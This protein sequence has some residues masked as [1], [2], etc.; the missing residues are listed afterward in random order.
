MTRVLRIPVLKTV[1]V[2]NDDGTPAVAIFYKEKAY[3]LVSLEQADFFDQF[4]LEEVEGPVPPFVTTPQRET[5]AQIRARL[6]GEEPELVPADEP[7]F[8]EDDVVKDDPLEDILRDMGIDKNKVNPNDAIMRVNDD[9]LRDG[10]DLTE[11]QLRALVGLVEDV[12]RHK[13]ERRQAFERLC[14]IPVLV[15][16]RSA[17]FTSPETRRQIATARASALGLGEQF[18]TI[19]HD[20]LPYVHGD[21]SKVV[22]PDGKG[23][24]VDIGTMLGEFEDSPIARDNPAVI[25]RDAGG[26]RWDATPT[27]ELERKASLSLRPKG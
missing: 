12:T 22:A 25:A 24:T 21:V 7:H 1:A 19:P 4:L 11:A 8:H 3:F 13:T 16:Q 20:L 17:K 27:K 6:L 14:T 2:P 23:G 18:M 15:L 9:V 26:I 10:N 5:P